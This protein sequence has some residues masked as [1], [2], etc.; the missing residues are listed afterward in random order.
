MANKGIVPAAEK[1]YCENLAQWR[2]W[3]K[4]NHGTSSGVWLVFF[5]K[6]TSRQTLDYAGALD[7]ALCYGWIDSLIKKLDEQ[8]YSRK[9]TPPSELQAVMKDNKAARENFDRLTPSHRTRYIMWIASAKRPDTREERAK[10]AA[11]LLEKD[12]KLGLR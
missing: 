7:E 9:F 6:G 2:S 4:K 12:Q 1:L 10:E 11:G 3:L 8:R 5:K